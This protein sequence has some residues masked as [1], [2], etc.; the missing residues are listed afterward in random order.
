MAAGAAK[1][2][3]RK[4]QLRKPAKLS[5]AQPV[6]LRPLARAKRVAADADDDTDQRAWLDW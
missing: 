3:P 5:K 1:R 4:A 2:K 6:A